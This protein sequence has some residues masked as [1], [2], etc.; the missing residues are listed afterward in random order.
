MHGSIVKD[1]TTHLS[2]RIGE[3]A[4]IT[5]SA[6]SMFDLTVGITVFCKLEVGGGQIN[7]HCEVVTIVFWKQATSIAH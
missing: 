4:R 1:L 7:R 5:L 2:R 3:V 6:A